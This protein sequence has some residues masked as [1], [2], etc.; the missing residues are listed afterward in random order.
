MRQLKEKISITKEVNKG[1]VQILL[2][3]FYAFDEIQLMIQWI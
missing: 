1:Y 3:V 2:I